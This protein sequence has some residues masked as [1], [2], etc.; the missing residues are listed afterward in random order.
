MSKSQLRFLFILLL[1]FTVYIILTKYNKL[2]LIENYYTY[3]KPY[4]NKNVGKKYLFY[5]KKEYNLNH[6]QKYFNYKPLIFGYTNKNMNILNKNY[7]SNYNKSDYNKFVSFITKLLIANSNFMILHSKL[8]YNES[9]L[10]K[11]INNKIVD[12]GHVAAP[13]ISN[14]INGKHSEIFDF[15]LTN[16]RFIMKTNKETLL[17]ISRNLNNINNINSSTRIGLDYKGSSSWLIT[18]DILN[19]LSNNKADDFNIKYFRNNINN[20]IALIENKIDI[21]FITIIYPSPGLTHFFNTNHNK[22]IL[23]LPIGDTLDN[24][25]FKKYYYY[26]TEYIDLNLVSDTYLPKK[27]NNNYYHPFKPSLKTISFYNYL[28]CHKFLETK[29]SYNIINIIYNN[30][31]LINNLDEF[32]KDKLNKADVS[33]SPNITLIYSSGTNKFFKENG[34]TTYNPNPLCKYVVGIKPCKNTDKIIRTLSF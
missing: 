30:L 25:F 12:I 14:A 33:A 20:L 17:V 2:L 22:D 24:V 10:C 6:F 1:L 15:S 18:H 9:D 23:I 26:E 11:N 3:F 31:N 19:E 13:I 7:K 28:I 5:K 32:K 21:I 16:L 4:Y 29:Y 8:F 34:Y 27:I